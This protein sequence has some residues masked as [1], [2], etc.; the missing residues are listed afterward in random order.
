[1]K[2]NILRAQQIKMWASKLL[3][4]EQKQSIGNDSHHL[5]LP[6]SISLFIANKNP[7]IVS[8]FLLHL[9]HLFKNFIFLEQ[10][11]NTS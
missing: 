5:S 8:I 7:R 4:F 10:S 3:L 9:A 6:P 11:K 2:Q 1:M